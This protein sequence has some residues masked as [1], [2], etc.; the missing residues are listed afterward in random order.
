MKK[1]S[2]QKSLQVD[3]LQNRKHYVFGKKE[4]QEI[5]I[6]ASE[7]GYADAVRKFKKKFPTITEITIRPWIKRYKENLIEQRKANKEV[8][9]KIGQTRGRPFSL[10]AGLDWKLWAMITSLRTAGA[11]INQHVV[12]RILIGLVQSY[13]EKLGKYVNFEITQP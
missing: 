12:R 1:L 8:A 6:F 7:H 4:K 13:P 11:G 5:A 2:V 9:L 3:K 10:D